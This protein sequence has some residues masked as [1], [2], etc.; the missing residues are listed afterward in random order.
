MLKIESDGDL[1]WIDFMRRHGY[2]E[3]DILSIR[4]MVEHL[5]S[6]DIDCNGCVISPNKQ[7]GDAA[8]DLSTKLVSEWYNNTWMSQEGIDNVIISWI[9]CLAGTPLADMVF[10]LSIARVLLAFRKSLECDGLQ[11][12]V[13][14]QNHVYAMVDVSFVD[15]CIM[16]SSGSAQ[17]IVAKTVAVANLAY[18]TFLCFKLLLNFC[19]GKSEA[20]VCFGGPGKKGCEMRIVFEQ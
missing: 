12:E 1:G 15:D 4:N 14:V 11:S 7:G 10:T 17:E 18:S 5:A 3:P 6:W 8:K 20:F 13:C 19:P 2:S 16:P 9:G